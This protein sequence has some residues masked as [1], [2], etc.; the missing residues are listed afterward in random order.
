MED[1]DNEKLQY[2]IGRFS[3]PAD[4]IEGDRIGWIKDIEDL[5]LKLRNEIR[6][7]T[8]EM[9]DV[10]YRP[11]GWTV[12]QVVHHLVDSHMNAYLRFKLT[13][14]ED[15]PAIRP[16]D[17]KLWANL[18]EA[19]NSAPEPSVALLEALHK[20]WVISLRSMQPPDFNRRYFH[21]EY[22]KEYS[23]HHALALYAWHGKHHLEHIRIVKR[24]FAE[25]ESL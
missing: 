25:A 3:P 24:K 10:P 12:R 23:L 16:Y 18:D 8:E 22:K 20:R 19:K 14:T 17:E 6:N 21:P 13:L 9:L 7:F 11:E 5:P 2:P 1:Q 4:T 15:L